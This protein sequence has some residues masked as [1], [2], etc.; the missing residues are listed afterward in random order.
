VKRLP[1]VFLFIVL[2]SASWAADKPRL[3][4]LISIDQFRA[5][6]LTRFEDLFLPAKS[7]GKVG[8][9]KYLM[10]HGAYF[11]NAHHDH[12]PLATGPG[13]SIHFT[14]SPPYKTGI[15]GNDWW[16]YKLGKEVYCVQDDRFPQIGAPGKTI[17]I[18]PDHLRVTTVGDELK[19]ATGGQAKVFGISLKDRAAALMAGHLADGVFWQND[20]AGKWVSSGYWCKNGALPAWLTALNDER[21][22]DKYFGLTWNTSVPNSALARLWTPTGKY[23]ANPFGLGT[24]FPHVLSVGQTAPNPNYYK[25]F[26][27][28]PFANEYVLTSARRLI[29]AEKL[30][31]DDI[32][33]I[34]AINL[35]SNDYIGH[36]YGPDSAEVLDVTVQTDRYLSNFFN[37][38]DR[39]VPGGLANI[40]IV[41]TADHGA[42]PNGEALRDHGMRGGN[43][44]ED[45]LKRA[46]NAGL[47]AKYGPGEYVIEYK[48]PYLWL[49]R[50]LLKTKGI[51][52]EKAEEIAAESVV[53]K[54]E[55][56]YTA[57]T[58]T[59]ALAGRLP[60][61]DIGDR[62]A[63]SYHPEVSGDVLVVN[64]PGYLPRNDPKGTSHSE[65][66]A[67]DTRVPLLMAGFGIRPGT[68]TERVSTLGTAPTLSFLLHVQQPSGC[69]GH[70]L[71][72][73]MLADGPNRR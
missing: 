55:G 71:S 65:P 30:G 13:H 53:E 12:L 9:F 46:A 49:N 27:V 4:V 33:D 15:V 70:I 22:D 25:A 32:P 43:L 28:T 3:V 57:Y 5:D 69:E 48:E 18:S 17:G 62:V 23:A 42:S 39:L 64:K 44:T 61:T 35:A 29:S 14:G 2:A 21:L 36:N 63:R 7:N 16:D 51:S 34:L 31:Q 47:V 66:Y 52:R 68:Y 8:G 72:R 10:E 54:M 73:A 58:R 6:Y 38:L 1:L 41:V 26:A 60:R 59:D 45:A 19:M 24:E 11:P 56:V 40:T 50:A 20:D 37:E 67:Y